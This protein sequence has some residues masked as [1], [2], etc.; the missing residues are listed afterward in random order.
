MIKFRCVWAALTFL[1]TPRLL[2]GAVF[3]MG[4]FLFTAGC[5]NKDDKGKDSKF[6]S[7]DSAG[8][9]FS[10]PGI[11]GG[12]PVKLDESEAKF[13]VGFFD[14]NTKRVFCTGTIISK[15]SILTAAHCLLDTT[16]NI[17]IFVGPEVPHSDGEIG[18]VH[19]Y[20]IKTFRVSPKWRSVDDLPETDQGDLAV[21]KIFG[22]FREL[23]TADSHFDELDVHGVSAFPV[24]NRDKS[25]LKDGAILSVFGF[26]YI[27]IQ[28]RLRATWL[29][30][31]FLP[32]HNAAFGNFEFSIDQKNG[33]GVCHGDSGGPAFLKKGIRSI[34]VGVASRGFRDFDG[35]CNTSSVFTTVDSHFE[36]IQKAVEDFSQ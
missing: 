14:F 9:N 35:T 31:I 15:N 32:I 13:V 24:F 26:G 18:R 29:Q 21:V 2:L 34:L 11:I 27:D 12:Q 22:E 23:P 17:Q 6:F 28:K 36:F 5:S 16:R 20:K 4:T 3:L 7:Y 33:M 10:D 30:K 8:E 1:A 25:L 19:F